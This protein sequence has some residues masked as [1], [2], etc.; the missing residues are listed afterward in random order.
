MQEKDQQ[1]L[2]VNAFGLQIEIEVK[3]DQQAQEHQQK[4]G[5]RVTLTV[6]KPDDGAQNSL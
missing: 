1:E 5:T 3:Q 6:V 4:V 2:L